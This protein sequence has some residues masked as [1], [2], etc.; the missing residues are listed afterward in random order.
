MTYPRFVFGKRIA[1]STFIAVLVSDWFAVYVL[2]GAFVICLRG[3][4]KADRVTVGSSTL[5]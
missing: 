2:L 5:S 3:V 4:A 1:G